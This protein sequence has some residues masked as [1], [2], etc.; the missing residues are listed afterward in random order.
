MN[1]AIIFVAGILVGICA[2]A[3]VVNMA[4]S[5]SEKQPPVEEKP[6]EIE[7]EDEKKEMENITKENHYI[8]LENVYEKDEDDDEAIE[9]EDEEDSELETSIEYNNS[10]DEFR[11]K[12]GEVIE[13][14]DYDE[15]YTGYV[16][17]FDIYDNYGSPI[18][19]YWFPDSNV[20][21]DDEGT[22]LNPIEKYLGEFTSIKEDTGIR[23]NPLQKRYLVHSEN[24]I[25]PDEFWG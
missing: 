15:A 6:E 4:K 20:L 10:F 14:L 21:T 23:N 12:Y 25:N 9:E 1:K 17:E 8:S 2:E 3:V 7:K 5:K 22:I 24:N 16:D 19:L 13:K 11:K 18:D